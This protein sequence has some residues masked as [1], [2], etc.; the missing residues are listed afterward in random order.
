MLGILGGQLS[1][2]LTH[3]LLNIAALTLCHSHHLSKSP[4]SNPT[5]AT[6]TPNDS[7]NFNVVVKN[8]NNLIEY[9]TKLLA[10]LETIA[11][12]CGSSV[13]ESSQKLNVSAFFLVQA[14]AF[15]DASAMSSMISLRDHK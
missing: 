10:V 3:D 1:M 11:L 5:A 7:Q 8:A 4:R 13:Y 2:I 15:P 9:R 6:F 12:C 14:R